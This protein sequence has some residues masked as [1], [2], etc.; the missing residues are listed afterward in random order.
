MNLY[1]VQQQLCSSFISQSHLKLSLP[2]SIVRINREMGEM[3]RSVLTYTTHT[4]ICSSSIT[5]MYSVCSNM[6]RYIPLYEVDEL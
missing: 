3:G 4:Y 5:D 1:S 6:I 2:W